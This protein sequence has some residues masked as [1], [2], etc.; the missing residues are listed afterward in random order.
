MLPLHVRNK[1]TSA[2]CIER[3][4]SSDGIRPHRK[5]MEEHR[6]VAYQAVE[7]FTIRMH[8]TMRHFDARDTKD[9]GD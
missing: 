8:K 1:E 7:G 6:L 9:I 4:L 2:E 3:A 5:N